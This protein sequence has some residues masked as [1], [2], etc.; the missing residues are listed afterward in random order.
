MP[1]H[2]IG[3][4]KWHVKSNRLLLG[5]GICE[6]IEIYRPPPSGGTGGTESPV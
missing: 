3:Y 6:D 2:G 5:F 1:A 4:H